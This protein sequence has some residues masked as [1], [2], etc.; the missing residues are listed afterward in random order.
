MIEIFGL[1][2]PSWTPWAIVA[3]IVILIVAFIL[4]GVVDELKKK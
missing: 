2:L 4:K 3:I 1:E